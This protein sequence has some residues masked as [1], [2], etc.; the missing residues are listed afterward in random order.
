MLKFF[1][2]KLKLMNSDAENPPEDLERIDDDIEGRVKVEQKIYL[3]STIGPIIAKLINKIALTRP[4][5]VLNFIC[6]ELEAIIAKSEKDPFNLDYLEISKKPPVVSNTPL[7]SNQ[8]SLTRSKI[9]NAINLDNSWTPL[10]DYV[11]EKMTPSSARSRLQDA[12]KLDQ[13]IRT[14]RPE[15]APL[16]KSSYAKKSDDHLDDDSRTQ[17]P[18]NVSSVKAS[19]RSQSSP[20]KNESHTTAVTEHSNGPQ[21]TDV[22]EMPKEKQNIRV[23]VLGLDGSGK[24]S[25]LNRL[26]GISDGKVRPTVGFRPISMTF[27]DNADIKFFDLGGTVVVI[28]TMKISERSIV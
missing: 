1:K 10:P 16:T 22:I 24:T 5:P 7:N 19:P 11:D 13:A 12:K 15:T 25:I 28:V 27:G 2:N 26:T 18:S 17:S 21:S 4:K 9:E 8:I 6:E 3:A 14:N 23:A 20:S